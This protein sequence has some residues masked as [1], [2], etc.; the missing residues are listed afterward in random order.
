MGVPQFGHD[1]DLSPA[2][3]LASKCFFGSSLLHRS[4]WC[5]IA[6]PSTGA[7]ALIVGLEVKETPIFALS[8]LNSGRPTSS[9]PD[10]SAQPWY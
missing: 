9:G 8:R 1:S 10:V 7:S 2:H 5:M 3:D 4:Q 6:M